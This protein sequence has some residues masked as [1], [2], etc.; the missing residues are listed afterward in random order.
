MDSSRPLIVRSL[1]GRDMS[2]ETWEDGSPDAPVVIDDFVEY[3]DKPFAFTSDGKLF[4]IVRSKDSSFG[5]RLE[6]DKKGRYADVMY[7][8]FS[9]TETDAVELLSSPVDS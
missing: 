9:I 4:E 8:G 7:N 2:G 5:Y 3:N 6:E 1:D